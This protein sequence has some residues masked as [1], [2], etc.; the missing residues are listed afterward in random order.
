[1]YPV[2]KGACE[3]LL[4]QLVENGEGYLVTA[5][6]ISPENKFFMGNAE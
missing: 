4:E 1:M 5:P 2:L 6:S 3:F